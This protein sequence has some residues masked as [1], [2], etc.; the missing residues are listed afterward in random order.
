MTTEYLR[1]PFGTVILALALLFFAVG[2]PAA[3]QQDAAAGAD[4]VA[5]SKGFA[6]KFM[7]GNDEACEAHYDEA[8]KAAF[9]RDKAEATRAQL[10]AQVGAFK[11][12]GEAWHEDDVQGYRRYRVPVV[13]E[14]ATLD[15]R[16]VFDG[17]D[18]IGGFFAV[19]HEEPKE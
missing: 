19:P 17:E 15:F 11:S 5:L 9:P 4:L 3:A 7:A 8:M 14:K 6:E 16:L 2:F 10:I 18:R 13:F 1:I 12:V